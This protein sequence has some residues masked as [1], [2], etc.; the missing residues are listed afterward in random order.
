MKKVLK[1]VAIVS[2]LLLT[3]FA[4]G[5]GKSQEEKY[6]EARN[7]FIALQQ[8][9]DKDYQVYNKKHNT[10]KNAGKPTLEFYEEYVKIVGTFQKEADKKLQNMAEL[11]KGKLELTKDVEQVKQEYHKKYDF[12][13]NMLKD[14]EEGV[15]IF[16]NKK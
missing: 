14:A 15:K 9:F 11:A 7:E 2:M 13:L 1:I 16:K 6:T 4:G 8:Q 3:V 12:Y 10:G 5:C